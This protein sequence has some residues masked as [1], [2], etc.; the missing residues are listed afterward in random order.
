MIL[1]HL[2][3][4]VTFFSIVHSWKPVIFPTPHPHPTPG[5]RRLSYFFYQLKCC[6][7]FSYVNSC[8]LCK[9]V[10]RSAFK[11]SPAVSLR[12]KNQKL[13]LR[14]S[15]GQS[16]IYRNVDA[17][18]LSNLPCRTNPHSPSDLD[19]SNG[20]TR[21][22]QKWNPPILPQLKKHQA[23]KSWTLQTAD[24]DCRVKSLIHHKL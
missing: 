24:N 19:I 3:W 5:Q 4:P 20:K 13:P 22:F 11:T 23:V 21:W 10:K 16:S 6:K 1:G 17:V 15:S 14:L 9:C 7:V 18:I 8:Y 2:P 12:Q